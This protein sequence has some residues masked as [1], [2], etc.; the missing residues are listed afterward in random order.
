MPR[1]LVASALA[2]AGCNSHEARPASTTAAAGSPAAP[3]APKQDTAPAAPKQDMA[4]GSPGSPPPATPATPAKD[5]KEKTMDNGAHS[6]AGDKH[7][8]QILHEDKVDG[9]TW[10]RAA[11][12]VPVTIAWV[13]VSGAWKPV[14]RIEIT[15]TAEQR[16]FTKFGADGQMLETTIQ[17]PPPPARPA[18]A[19]S[20]TPTPTPTKPSN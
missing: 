20:P 11:S 12:E 14:T 15:A 1:W 2:L 19:H 10:T 6:P 4:A 17:A 18:P 5:P 8:G 7:P 16:R 9:R 3:V 13:Q